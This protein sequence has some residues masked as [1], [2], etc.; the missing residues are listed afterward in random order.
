ML[1]HKEVADW[2]KESE[3]KVTVACDEYH[4]HTADC[5]HGPVMDVRVL[6]LLDT[7][8]GLYEELKDDLSPKMR[9]AFARRGLCK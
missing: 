7:L 3:A 9:K 5:L 2:R 6:K 8:E 4:Q 1:T